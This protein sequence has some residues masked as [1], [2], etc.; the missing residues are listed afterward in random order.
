MISDETNNL[1]SFTYDENNKL[2]LT[3][4]NV[5]LAEIVFSIYYSNSKIEETINA[6]NE[7]GGFT[8]ENLAKVCKAVNSENS[9][10]LLVDDREAIC[11][12]LRRTSDNNLE[13]FKHRLT[14]ENYSLIN[15]IRGLKNNNNL[16]EEER[17]IKDNYSFATKL[18]HY[19]CYYLFANDVDRDRYPIYDSVVSSYVKNSQSYRNRDNRDINDY[20]NYVSIIDEIIN[21]TGISRNGFDHLIWLTNRYHLDEQKNS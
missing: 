3:Q 7:E 15:E 14:D 6:L 21:G 5:R 16:C 19:L 1:D 20:N 17:T 18:C 8:S 13:N 4:K 12:Y 9:T 11:R 2:E 10:H